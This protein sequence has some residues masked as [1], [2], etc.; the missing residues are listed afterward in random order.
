MTETPTPGPGAA[1]DHHRARD[2]APEPAPHPR[3]RRRRRPRRLRRRR[4]HRPLRQAPASRRPAPSTRRRSTPRR[5]RSGSRASSG[6]ACAPTPCATGTPSAAPHDRLRRATAT[7][8]SPGPWAGGRAARRRPAAH[9]PRRRLHARPRRRLAPH[10]RR[11]HRRSRRSPRRS[12]ASPPACPC[13]SSSRSRARGRVALETPGRPARSPGCTATAPATPLLGAVRDAR[14]PRR[15]RSTRSSTARPRHARAPPPPRRRLAASR[16]TSMSAS[17]YWKRGRDDEA[18]R[19]E[20][21]DFNRA[22]R[23]RA[24]DRS[25]GGTHR[26]SCPVFACGVVPRALL[27]TLR[28]SRWR[29]RLQ[30]LGQGPGGRL[31]ARPSAYTGGAGGEVAV[32]DSKGFSERGVKARRGTPRS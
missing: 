32:R 28:K 29:L 5:S 27:D 20:K 17:G 18:W 26:R 9:G 7:R 10:G 21:A 19:A 2:G 1:P 24:R 22:G 8:A 14:L 11:P 13:T 3:R 23:R 30:G 12:C 25:E 15:R 16:A 31:S 4:V 6:R